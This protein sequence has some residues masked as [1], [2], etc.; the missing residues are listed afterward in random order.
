M[1]KITT[2]FTVLVLAMNLDAQQIPMF[3]ET[4]FMRL[5]YN[6]A[7]TGYNGS[8]NVYGFYRNQWVNLPATR[9]PWAP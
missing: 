9:L 1:K 7:L 4:Y 8:T 2:L 3:S 6:P 5:L